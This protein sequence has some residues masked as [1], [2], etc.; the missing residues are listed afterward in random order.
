MGKILKIALGVLVLLG[1]SIGVFYFIDSRGILNREEGVS[2]TSAVFLTNGQVYFGKLDNKFGP[3]LRLREAKVLQTLKS[4]EE[5][6]STEEGGE[7]KTQQKITLRPL[8]LESTTL[9]PTSTVEINRS[10]VL[11][12]ERIRSDSKLLEALNQQ[13]QQ[14]TQSN[15]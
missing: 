5:T 13:A 6:P 1:L 11:L 10:H 8:A 3:Y 9:G 4:L 7:K 14:K 12:I 2:D 15:Q